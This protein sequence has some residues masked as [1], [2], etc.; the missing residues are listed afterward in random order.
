MGISCTSRASGENPDSH[1]PLIFAPRCTS[2]WQHQVCQSLQGWGQ[3][4]T[5]TVLPDGCPTQHCATASRPWPRLRCIA[6]EQECLC[7]P[8][9]GGN[10]SWSGAWRSRSDRGGL[11]LASR[12]W[13]S[14]ASDAS[15]HTYE[16]ARGSL[17]RRSRWSHR[18]REFCSMGFNRR[19]YR[20]FGW[21]FQSFSS[22]NVGDR[23]NGKFGHWRRFGCRI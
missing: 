20:A 23:R 8:L 19:W 3:L 17:G 9:I 21:S 1:C 22:A 5:C 7:Q 15:F 6:Q 16:T 13:R 18:G 10:E 12:C 2:S 4:Q 14:S 11:A